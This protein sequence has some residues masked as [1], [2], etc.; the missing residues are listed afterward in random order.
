M[1]VE[2]CVLEVRCLWRCVCVGGKGFV[3]VCVHDL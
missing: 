2:V 3:E 1:F